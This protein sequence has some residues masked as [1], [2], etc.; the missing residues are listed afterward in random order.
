MQILKIVFALIAI[1]G[2][3]YALFKFSHDAPPWVKIL[4]LVAG[5]ATLIGTIIVLPQALDALEL[6]LHRLSGYFTPSEEELRRRADAQAKK[7]AEEQARRQRVPSG[8]RLEFG[9]A[10]SPVT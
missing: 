10:R 3:G 4:S 6:T 9:V 7:E 5:V 8:M 1:G 2:P